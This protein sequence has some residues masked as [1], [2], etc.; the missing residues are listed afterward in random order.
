MKKVALRKNRFNK[1]EFSETSWTEKSKNLG[2]YIFRRI[3][4]DQSDKGLKEIR[5][6][7]ILSGL[8]IS[9]KEIQQYVCDY[10]DLLESQKIDTVDITGIENFKDFNLDNY[11]DSI[12]IPKS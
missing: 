1:K 6:R 8:I 9:S 2:E 3:S 7:H 5:P 4:L 11:L 12:T 10:L